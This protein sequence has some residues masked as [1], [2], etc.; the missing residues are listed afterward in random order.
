MMGF[1][2]NVYVLKYEGLLE[3]YFK[4]IFCIRDCIYVLKG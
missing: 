1:I 2:G 3:F 4:K